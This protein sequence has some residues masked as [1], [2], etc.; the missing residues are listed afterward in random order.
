MF[1]IGSMSCTAPAFQITASSRPS[2]GKLL[3]PANTPRINAT[4][5]DQDTGPKS[6]ISSNSTILYGDN[7]NHDCV[8]DFLWLTF[9]TGQ[10][11]F[12]YPS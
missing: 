9:Y 3:E 12:R 1:F 5:A 8:A 11:N 7:S 2:T 6:F 4:A 10:T